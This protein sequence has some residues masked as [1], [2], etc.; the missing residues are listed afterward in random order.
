[1]RRGIVFSYFYQARPGEKAGD[2]TRGYFDGA[3][4]DYPILNP[5]MHPDVI[6]KFPPTPLITALLH[7]STRSARGY[8]YQPDLPEARDAQQEIVDFFKQNLK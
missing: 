3:S 2:L 7:L 6:A 5:A 4:A 1:M 8:I